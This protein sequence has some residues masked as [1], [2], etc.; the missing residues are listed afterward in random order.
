MEFFVY[1][2]GSLLTAVNISTARE[3]PPKLL[4]PPQHQGR[5]QEAPVVT[6][7][8]PSP[9]TNSQGTGHSHNFDILPR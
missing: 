3:S 1:D 2:F 8:S 6:S 4:S 7:L 9:C 5:P